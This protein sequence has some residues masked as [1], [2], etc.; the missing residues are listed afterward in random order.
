L[1]RARAIEWAGCL[2]LA[3]TLPA[4]TPLT[5]GASSGAS[6][7]FRPRQAQ[8]SFVVAGICVDRMVA[9]L[10]SLPGACPYYLK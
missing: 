10:E 8:H 5:S 2:W 3:R 7:A 4:P 6:G 1:T 9:R